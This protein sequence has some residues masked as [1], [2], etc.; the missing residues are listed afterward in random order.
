[1]KFLFGSRNEKKVMLTANENGR[2][3]PG[4]IKE[5]RYAFCKEP[6]GQCFC[7]RGDLTRK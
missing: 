7:A 4:V 1:M 6:R 3:C 5:E 2:N